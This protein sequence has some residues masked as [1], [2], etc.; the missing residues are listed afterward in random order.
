MNRLIG[1]GLMLVL[2]LVVALSA[3]TANSAEEKTSIK[4][5]M[6][7]CMKGGLCAKVASG[8]ASDEEKKTLLAMFTALSKNKPPMG[9]EASWKEKTSALIDA[10]KA[11]DGKA[12]KKAANCAACHKVHKG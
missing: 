10:V 1:L 9:E 8:K 11:N 7:V 6:K 3:N 12:L 2:G 4:E 5:V